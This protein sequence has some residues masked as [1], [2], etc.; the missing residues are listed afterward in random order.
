MML[1]ADNRIQFVELFRPVTGDPRA[2]L[3]EQGELI[4]LKT[5]SAGP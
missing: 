2:L 1:D 5:V 4:V 3:V